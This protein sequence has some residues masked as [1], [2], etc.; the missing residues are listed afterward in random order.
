MI[1][2]KYGHILAI[3]SAAAATNCG[4]P[5]LIAYTTSKS[6]VVSFMSSLAEELR[7]TGLGD[8]IKTT[9]VLPYFIN[10][11]QDIMDFVNLRFPAYEPKYV[12]DKIVEGLL[13]DKETVIVIW[14]G[15]FSHYFTKYVQTFYIL[16]RIPEENLIFRIFPKKL[17]QLIMDVIFQA[18]TLRRLPDISK[19]N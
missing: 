16:L 14:L 4:V 9:C 7:V 3:S 19:Q 8:F 18:Q 5:F 1:K 15:Q 2:N 17:N 11:R 12:A 6:A 13:Y 10:T